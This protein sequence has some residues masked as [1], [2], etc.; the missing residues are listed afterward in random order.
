MTGTD[1]ICE[2]LND[3][4]QKCKSEGK[5]YVILRASDIED[6]FDIARTIYRDPNKNRYPAICSTMKRLM[7]DKDDIVFATPSEQS[8]DSEHLL[9]SA[10]Q[11]IWC[12]YIDSRPILA[13]S[14]RAFST[15]L[16]A[17][18]LRLVRI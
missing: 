10:C 15:T 4:F 2:L 17:I 16:T 9:F 18:C 6:M 7:N 12:M 3:Y 14:G 1:K 11:R 13:R 5:E 8:L